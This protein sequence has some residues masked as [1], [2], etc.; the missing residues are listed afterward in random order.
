MPSLVTFFTISILARIV[1]YEL[2]SLDTFLGNFPYYLN[3]NKDS[4]V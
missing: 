2:D 3:I 1:G 4:K